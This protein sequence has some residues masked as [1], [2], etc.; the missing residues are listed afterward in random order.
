MEQVDEFGNVR[1]SRKINLIAPDKL[2]K[3]SLE[4]PE[5]AVADARTPIR[6]KVRLT[7]AN[8]VPVTVRAPLT[9]EADRGRWLAVDLNS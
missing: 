6:I 9:L 2:G 8:G 5:T 4:A 3:L 1:D 7:D